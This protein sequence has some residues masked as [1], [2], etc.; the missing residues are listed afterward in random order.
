[1]GAFCGCGLKPPVHE[2]KKV[3]DEATVK[4]NP[5]PLPTDQS[6]PP[7]NSNELQNKDQASSPKPQIGAPSIPREPEPEIPMQPT[8][9]QPEPEVEQ[10]AE[11]TS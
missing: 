5:K 4:K 11:P 2:D 6:Q 10:V 7:K 3:H 8:E 9:A 1:M